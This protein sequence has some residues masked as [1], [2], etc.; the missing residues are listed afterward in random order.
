MIIASAMFGV[1][2]AIGKAHIPLLLMTASVGIK[3]LLNPILMSVTQLNI[4]GAALSTAAG[5]IFMSVTGAMLLKKYLSPCIS[6]PMCVR[7]PFFGSV[8]CA[9]CAYA[10]NLV[11]PDGLNNALCVAVSVISGAFVYGISLIINRDFRKKRQLIKPVTFFL[12]KDLKNP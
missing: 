11:L 12:Q 8:A 6:I 2:Q 5:Y 7:R 1:F 9:L 10:V 3:S 4:S